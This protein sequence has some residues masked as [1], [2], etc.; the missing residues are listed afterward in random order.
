MELEKGYENEEKE[1][2]RHATENRVSFETAAKTKVQIKK[3]G[4]SGYEFIQMFK[5]RINDEINRNK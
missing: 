2:V 5:G 3:E 1:I 4:L